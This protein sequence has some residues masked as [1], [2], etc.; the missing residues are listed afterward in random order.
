M[1]QSI[2]SREEAKAQGLT[3]YFTGKPCKHG[4][5]CER[6]VGDWKCVECDKVACRQRYA[7][8]PEKYRAANRQWY[9]DN[10]EKV[11]DAA[12]KWNTAN[13]EKHKAFIRQWNT[14]NSERN[15]ETSRQWRMDNREKSNAAS[16]KWH[17]A[18][19]KRRMEIDVQY[20][21]K[22][23]LRNRLNQAL[24]GNFKSGS[25]V[26]DLGCSIAGL[27]LHLEDKFDTNMTWENY[28]TYWHIDHII[29]LASFDLTDR[30]QFLRAVHWTNLQP[31][32]WEDN[33]KKG[34]RVE[35]AIAA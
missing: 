24:K 28:G 9:E 22:V 27:K 11:K 20:R 3:R 2:I 23:Q 31:L 29:P 6:N 8:S 34:S 7:A 15:K 16:R 14:D 33:L 13:P 35:P 30:E 17:K 4:H 12:R 5:V 32:Y 26:A 19:H 18:N 21:L 10:S 1:L 25:A